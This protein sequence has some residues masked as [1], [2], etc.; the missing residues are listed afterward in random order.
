MAYAETDFLLAL[1]KDDDWLGERAETVYETSEDLW[2]S[3]YTLLELMLV[4]YR[5]GWNVLHVVASATQLVEVRG[6][7]EDIIAAASFVEDEGFTPFD[8]LHLV[9]SETAAIV[10][11]D[12]DYDAFSDRV[13]LESVDPTGE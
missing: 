9:E 6:D 3:P 4:A 5:E 12:E 7:T 2:T 10:S 8:A 13:A 1:I 11:S